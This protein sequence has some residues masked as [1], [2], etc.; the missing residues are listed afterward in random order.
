MDWY[1]EFSKSVMNY[2]AL[3]GDDQ[4]YKDT[5]MAGATRANYLRLDFD[6]I[7][8]LYSYS[9]AMNPKYAFIEQLSVAKTAIFNLPSKEAILALRPDS[10]KDGLYSQGSKKDYVYTVAEVT[11]RLRGHGL[12][13]YAFD[14]LTMASILQEAPF[15]VRV[16][17]LFPVDLTNEDAALWKWYIVFE[18]KS[19]S[20]WFTQ[21]SEVAQFQ[22]IFTAQTGTVKALGKYARMHFITD[23]QWKAVRTL[24]AELFAKTGLAV[25]GILPKHVT[26]IRNLDWRIIVRYQ[27]KLFPVQPS[28]HVAHLLFYDF[29]PYRYA[30]AVIV[31]DMTGSVITPGKPFEALTGRFHSWLGWYLGIISYLVYCLLL[32][33]RVINMRSVKILLTALIQNKD[34]FGSSFIKLKTLPEDK[35]KSLGFD[36]LSRALLHF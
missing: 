23:F 18:S 22:S 10:F 26:V 4:V 7:V 14:T 24:V 2:R 12:I 9:N 36:R 29:D 16:E 15:A 6:N 20:N 1:D 19:S 13:C 11:H 33:P 25:F 31:A 8:S 30:E 5:L 17:D 21:V 27:G 34:H 35:M 3:I 28:G 32:K